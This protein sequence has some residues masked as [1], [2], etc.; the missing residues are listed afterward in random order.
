MAEWP[1]GDLACD[2]F[3]RSWMLHLT[4]SELNELSWECQSWRSSL[5]DWHLPQTVACNYTEPIRPLVKNESQQS[6][7][8]ERKDERMELTFTACSLRCL[9]IKSNPIIFGKIWAEQG[10]TTFKVERNFPD[11]PKFLHIQYTY[12]GFHVCSVSSWDPDD[13]SFTV[14]NSSPEQRLIDCWVPRGTSITLWNAVPQT[15][16]IL[17]CCVMAKLRI[18][19]SHNEKISLPGNGLVGM[20][21]RADN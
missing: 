19:T 12:R 3:E 6:R 8:V 7:G 14:P 1:Q 21:S 16:S 9:K 5:Q 11:F 4:L 2:H 10:K 17:R 20:W 18:W 15:Q 13:A